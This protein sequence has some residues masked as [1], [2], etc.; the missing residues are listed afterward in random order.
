MPG[1]SIALIGLGILIF[2]IGWSLLLNGVEIKTCSTYVYVPKEFVGRMSPR[3]SEWYYWRI[4]PVNLSNIVIEASKSFN[5][6]FSVNN[7]I[8]YIYI[9]IVGKPKTENYEGYVA[10][11]N[12]SNNQTVVYSS[13]SPQQSISGRGL[14]TT[15]FYQNPLEPGLYKL[16]L[17]F[18]T[19]VN[20]SKLLVYGPSSKEV[21]IQAIEITL[22]PSSESSYEQIKIDYIC[23]VSF[24]QAIASSTAVGVGI[25]M[26]VAGAFIESAKIPRIGFG[27]TSQLK[28]K[29]KSG[30]KR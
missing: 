1:K 22:A 13:L 16:A 2:V 6:T 11:L 7:T 14:N 4:A 15:L 30:K 18:N 17:S 10:I 27:K 25:S 5:Y 19:D 23:G 26:I 21:E 3:Y 28:P 29:K 12:A 20:I 8:G 24:T 9:E